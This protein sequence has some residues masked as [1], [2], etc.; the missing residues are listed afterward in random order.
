MKT[1]KN[2]ALVIAIIVVVSLFLFFGGWVISGG[3]LNS[4]MNGNEWTNERNWI[5]TPT[6]ITFALGIVI[7]WILFWKR[8]K[9]NQKLSYNGETQ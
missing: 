6:S 3:E 9:L 2:R 7:G 5:L 1:P 8:T 4:R